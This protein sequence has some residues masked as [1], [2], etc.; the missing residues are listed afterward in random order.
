MGHVNRFSKVEEIIEVDDEYILS[1]GAFSVD[2][3]ENK[4]IIEP[5]TSVQDE[6]PQIQDSIR[7]V[8]DTSMSL[9]QVC[10]FEAPNEFPNQE[11]LPVENSPILDLPIQEET[12]DNAHGSGSPPNSKQSI[13]EEELEQQ[14]PIYFPP[15]KCRL[16]FVHRCESLEY[17]EKPQ[18]QNPNF[19]NGNRNQ[20]C[21]FGN[22][23]PALNKR[24]QSGKNSPENSY[25]KLFNQEVERKLKE[26][27]LRFLNKRNKVLRSPT[28]TGGFG[29]GSNCGSPKLR[30]RQSGPN[31]DL[32]SKVLDNKKQGKATKQ[33][34]SRS[35]K[36]K[37]LV[38]RS[39][40]SEGNKRDES[41][42]FACLS[43]Q[44][45][46]RPKNEL[47]SFDSAASILKSD[48]TRGKL[49]H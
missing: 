18:I 46:S 41:S 45:Q 48:K 16:D 7:E 38:W 13:F 1:S 43:S 15:R 11:T 34:K 17:V 49:V 33:K 39:E 36:E 25:F 23:S 9:K 37:P 27:N 8:I 29:F 10:E 20:P 19:P 31:P 5:E 6:E 14:K 3:Y 32:F 28:K 21:N 40:D 42:F 2:N 4:K 47:T 44:V 24:K 35:P 22:K 30:L 12:P 26:N